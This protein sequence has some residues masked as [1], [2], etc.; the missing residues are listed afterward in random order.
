MVFWVQYTR[1]Q[2]KTEEKVKQLLADYLGVDLEDIENESV[3][4]IDL[5]MTAVDLTDFLEDLK[6]NGFDISR[7]DLTEIETFEDL[8]EALTLTA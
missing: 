4:T 5:H 8:V 6:T 1:Q 7:V 2:M 3:L